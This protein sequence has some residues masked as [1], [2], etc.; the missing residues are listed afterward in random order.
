MNNFFVVQFNPTVFSLPFITLH[1]YGLMYFIG[2]LFSIWLSIKRIDKEK[3]KWISKE[4]IQEILYVSFIG[5]IIG[6][7]IGYILFYNIK[8]LYLNP[9]F[10]FKI[11]HGGMSFHG[12]LIGVLIV[13]FYYSITNKLN[14]L[15]LSDFITKLVP[16]GIALGRLGNFI[17][18]ELWGNVTNIRLA[19]IFPKS[20]YED[21]VYLSNDSKW[22]YVFNKYQGLP[23]HPSQL[24]EMIFEG[25][26][27]FLFLNLLNFRKLP[28]GSCTSLFLIFYGVF[29]IILETFR[30]QNMQGLF[31]YKMF[32]MGQIL[33]FPMI[34]IGILLIIRSFYIY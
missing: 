6:G 21:I 13:L 32:S 22:S 10:I 30:S 23:R 27:I 15:K 11:W 26:V 2:L 34:I 7:R 18:G 19:M 9:M 31:I 33:S 8:L 5:I 28:I 4:E 24:Y 29:R 12:G 1:W 14:F 16:F 3:N 17:N 20:L 25:V